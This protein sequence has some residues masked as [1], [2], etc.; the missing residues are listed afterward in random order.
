MNN[1]NQL[2][3]EI[4]AINVAN[5]WDVCKP[6]DWADTNKIAAKLA[7][8]HSEVSEALEAIRHNDKENFTEEM[9]DVLIRVLD[10]TAGLGLDMDTTVAVKLEKNRHRGYKHGGKLI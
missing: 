1:L 5:G 8:I 2:G 9:A 6:E 7:L 10:T 4:L 3:V